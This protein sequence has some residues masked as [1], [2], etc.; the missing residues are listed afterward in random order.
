MKNYNEICKLIEMI[1][2]EDLKERILQDIV[3]RNSEMLEFNNLNYVYNNRGG[4]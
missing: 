2:I 1:N 3:Y 4:M